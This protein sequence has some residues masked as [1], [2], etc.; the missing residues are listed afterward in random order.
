MK[1]YHM[2]HKLNGKG[3]VSAL[4]FK[5]PRAIDLTRAL[6]TNRPDAVT[7]EKCLALLPHKVSNAEVSGAGTASA[8]LPG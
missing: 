2:A 8:G 1:K 7:C 5:K 6:W 4:C 3:G